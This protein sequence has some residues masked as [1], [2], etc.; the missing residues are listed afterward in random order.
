MDARKIS[1]G[2]IDQPPIISWGYKNWR[3][4][5]YEP[6]V[7]GLWVS[8][9][10]K[11]IAGLK[12]NTCVFLTPTGNSEQEIEIFEQLANTFQKH[13]IPHFNMMPELNAMF[14]SHLRPRSAWANPSDA[15]PGIAQNKLY[16]KGASRLLNE[17]EY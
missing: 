12:H 4:R 5:L 11:A 3:D 1:T 9:I 16:A 10:V 7:F 8:N 14:D 17:C 6:D 2:S 15:H 13:N